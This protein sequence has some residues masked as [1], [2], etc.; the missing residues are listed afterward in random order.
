MSRFC[1]YVEIKQ[2]NS[3][4]KSVEQPHS[5]IRLVLIQRRGGQAQVKISV[6]ENRG[7]RIGSWGDSGMKYHQDDQR[8]DLL[9]CER[10]KHQFHPQAAVP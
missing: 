10:I 4:R 3:T 2:D 7:H 5:G 8:G 6:V 1:R 9:L